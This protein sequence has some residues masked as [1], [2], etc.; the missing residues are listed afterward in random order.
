MPFKQH[1][2]SD[3][4]SH[5]NVPSYHLQQQLE[6]DAIGK[7]CRLENGLLHPQNKV[8]GQLQI[9]TQYQFQLS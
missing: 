4:K 6:R 1:R 3:R 5:L 2:R 9:Q 7:G 8:T